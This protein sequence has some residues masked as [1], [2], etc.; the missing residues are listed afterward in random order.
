MGLWYS[1]RV[2]INTKMDAAPLGNGWADMS[3]G[4]PKRF[5]EYNS[6]L[7]SGTSIDLSG[8][9]TE[10][11]DKNNEKHS[12]D[13]ILTIDDVQSMS[14]ANVMGQDDDW[15][16]TALTEQASAP[17]HVIIQGSTISWDNSDYV[18]CW[19][20]FKNGEYAGNTTEPTFSINDANA[21]WTVR[22]ANEMGG[23]SEATKA[24]IPTGIHEVEK[25]DDSVSPIYNALGQRINANTKGLQ[26]SKNGKR[27]VK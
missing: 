21:T 3:G 4:W 2:L 8:R 6:Y 5:A 25:A 20:V 10:W 9:R 12:N 26:I 1:Y 14:L 11:T 7:S 13:P 27:I 18:F 17:T 23:L 16:P 15:D 22:A 19:V 24:V